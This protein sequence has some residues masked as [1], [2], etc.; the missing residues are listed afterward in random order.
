MPILDLDRL[1]AQLRDPNVESQEVAAETGV[2]R[3]EVGRA[4][5]LV[6]GMARAKADEITTLPTLLA[7]AVAR[8]ALQAG[9]GDVL[10]A[11][12]AHPG[13]E[14]SKE[15]KRGLH[16]L[17]SRGVTVPEPP[18]PAAPAVPAPPAETAVPAYASAVDGQGE[19]A[20]W[21][22]RPLP[23]KGIEVGQAVVGD[24][25]GLLDLQVVIL[26]RK[27]WRG[28]IQGLLQRGRDMGVVEIDRERAKSIVAAARARNDETGAPV[29]DG[30][31]LWLRHLGPAPPPEDVAERFPPLPP[32]EEDAALGASAALHDLPLLRGWLPE[33]PF[34]REIA[35]KL[36]EVAVSPLYV[37]EQQRGEQLA[38]T[39][40]RAVED[41]YDARRRPLVASRLF[42]VADHLE[43]AGVSV[44]ARAAAA[45]ARA[46]RRG[47]APQAIPFA[48]RLVEKAFPLGRSGEEPRAPSAAGEE[49]LI[50]APR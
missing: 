17:R 21:I 34:L 6:A 16:V 49:G 29:P 22:P 24:E 15:A 12:A 20:I 41:Y 26:G 13:K 30:A 50:V 19:Q 45:T 2:S 5:R 39:V 18:R 48:R 23:G 27:E 25:K 28:F 14:A 46:L 7:A 38:R 37:D 32:E 11:L 40:A 3:E 9:R 31:D 1:L 36:D 44:H 8:A 42:A 33:E 35:A 4:A 47:L 10:A 43:R